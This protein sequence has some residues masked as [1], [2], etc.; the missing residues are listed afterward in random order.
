[1]LSVARNDLIIQ[2]PL[3]QCLVLKALKYE[4]GWI[5][6]GKTRIEMFGGLKSVSQRISPQIHRMNG[7]VI[8]NIRFRS[9]IIFIQFSHWISRYQDTSGHI[10]EAHIDY[11]IIGNL[12]LI[13]QSLRIHKRNTDKAHESNNA[14]DARWPLLAVDPVKPR[15]LLCLTYRFTIIRQ[16]GLAKCCYVKEL[17]TRVLATK[18]YVLSGRYPSFSEVL[19]DCKPVTITTHE[20]VA[21]PGR[22][23]RDSLQDVETLDRIVDAIFFV[24]L[25]VNSCAP[26]R[27]LSNLRDIRRH[28]IRC[29][30]HR[31]SRPA[32]SRS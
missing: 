11:D 29:V 10:C 4:F 20:W 32:I 15:Q 9:L 5:K 16:E 27:E 14:Y 19:A 24:C 30:L 22:T 1:M 17:P 25:R 21:P 28:S 8:I 3:G 7:H 18:L 26:M 23:D 6:P 31:F 13:S 12:K 2:F